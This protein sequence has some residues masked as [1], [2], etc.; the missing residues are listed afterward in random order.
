MAFHKS[1]TSDNRIMKTKLGAFA[2]A[3]M[4]ALAALPIFIGDPSPKS[5]VILSD[6]PTPTDP[7]CD[8]NTPPPCTR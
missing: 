6:D 2:F 5:V 7:F 1:K 4:L 8:E 3:A